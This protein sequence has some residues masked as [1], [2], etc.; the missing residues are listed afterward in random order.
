M[1]K[2]FKNKTLLKVVNVFQKTYSNGKGNGFGDF[3]RGSFFLLQI[4]MTY[5]LKYDVDYKNH[6]I[7]QFLYKEKDT[8]CNTI[9]DYPNIYYIPGTCKALSK[10]LYEEFINYLNSENDETYYLYTNNYPMHTISDFQIE[11]IK[12]KFLPNEILNNAINNTMQSVHLI[13]NQYNVIHIRTGDRFILCNDIDYKFFADVSK[14]INNKIVPSNKYLI[15]SD[16]IEFKKL[17]KNKFPELIIYINDITHLGEESINV[18]DEYNATK[19]TL[20]D[21]F[22]M[23]KANHIHGISV[24]EHGTG[25]S[26]YCSKIYKIGYDFTIINDDKRHPTRPCIE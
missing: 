17:L 13:A 15:L 3:L 22:I 6:M 4:A 9:I 12:N 25:F 10:P 20:V 8:E 19:N 1:S 24:Y 2:Y 5:N 11:F 21:F 16:S 23:S 14:I 18:K 7:S 26:E